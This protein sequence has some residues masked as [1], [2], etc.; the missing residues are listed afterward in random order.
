MAHKSNH[1]YFFSAD[2]NNLLLF[3]CAAHEAWLNLEQLCG[4]QRVTETQRVECSTS[5]E[6]MRAW[7]NSRVG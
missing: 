1:K 3:A 2:V 5:S 6:A 7:F 4:Y